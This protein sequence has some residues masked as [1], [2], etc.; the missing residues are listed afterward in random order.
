MDYLLVNVS[1]SIKSMLITTVTVSIEYELFT[2]Y[3]SK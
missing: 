3:G 1:G 2:V